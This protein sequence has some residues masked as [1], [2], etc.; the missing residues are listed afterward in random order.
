MEVVKDATM[1]E[2]KW[3]FDEDVTNAFDDMLARSIPQHDEMRRL[4][5]ELASPFV[6]DG[7]AVLD[8]GCSRGAA[9]APF[10]DRFGAR[11][12][13]VGV[14]VSA[15]MLA[16]A[17]ER[18]S[19]FIRCGVVDVLDLD[20][21]AKYPPV[22][23]SV[24]LCVLTLQFV[25]IEHR[26]RIMRDAFDATVPG[27]CL[28]LVEKVLGA[29]AALDKVLVD[30]YLAMK[31][32]NGYTRDQVDRKRLSLEGVLVPVTAGW[33]EELLRQAGF[34]QVDCFWR[35]CCFAGWLAVKR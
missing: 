20:L 24:T 29:T 26:Q 12:R 14:E 21:R 25:P 9:M 17:R 3:T 35:W 6:E 5:F 7:T 15:P 16:A 4:C 34:H 23:A 1:P 33:N 27:G 10:V 13:H 19:G 30:R 8:L 32:E 2:G 11:V 31:L 28:V 22:R 18:F